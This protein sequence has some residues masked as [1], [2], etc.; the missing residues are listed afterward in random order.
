MIL[1]MSSP[2]PTVEERDQ[3][4]T[5][6][7]P[8]A[9][10][11]SENLLRRSV[12]AVPGVLRHYWAT[13]LIVAI[14][15]VVG[16][17]TGA[18]FHNVS[19]SSD[20]YQSVAY[21]LPPLQ[22]GRW[23]TF[24]SGAFFS[25]ELILYVPILGLLVLAASTFERRV[26]HWQTLVA[27]IGGQVAGAMLT[28]LFLWPFADS[29]W[30]WAAT[31]ARQVDVGIS[32]GG[33]AVL[34]ALTACM[35]PVWRV[36]VRA[37]ISAYLIAM[38]LNAGLL[39]DVEHLLAWCLGLVLG[40]L[41][42]GRRPRSP[43]IRFG[44]RTQRGVVALVI[45]VT[46]I[47]GLVEAVFPGNGGPFHAGNQPYEATSV[48]LGLVVGAVLLLVMADGL[49]RGRRFAW[50]VVTVLLLLSFV[51]LIAVDPSAERTAAMVLLGAQVVLLLATFRAFSARTRR[52]SFRRAGRRLLVVAA[53]LF[54][55]TGVGFL[56]LR[57][58]FVPEASIADMIGEFFSRL[59]FTS[60][61]NIEPATTAANWFVTS[62]G[63]VWIIAI[64]V[65]LVGL[66][67]SSRRPRPQPEQDDR[68]RQ[69]LRTNPATSIEWML[70]W[71]GNTIWFSADGQT[72]IGFRV[73]GS[74]ALCLSDPVGPVGSRV[75]A[76]KE[77]DAYCFERGWLP[78]LFAASEVTAEMAPE[79]GW[80]AVQIAEDSVLALEHLEFKG[81]AWQDVRTAINKAGKQEIRLVVTHW[82]D[83]KPV[84]S[85]QLR[86]ISSGWV[87][88]KSLP[89]M[90]FT[91]GSLAEAEDPDVR[92]HLAIDADSTIEGFTSW[93]PVGDGGEIVGWT[94][95]LMRRRDEG[96]RPVM[97]FLIGA[98]ALQLKDEGYR[99]ISLSA[100]PLAKAPEHLAVNSDQ[101]VLQKLLDFLGN[102]LE[103]YYG[104]RSLLAFKMKFQPE[105]RPMYLVY[106]DESALLEIGIAIARAYMP[107]AKLKDW[108]KM[109]WEMLIPA[110]HD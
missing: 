7:E 85:D 23:W 12:R 81:K 61:G 33:F 52:K 62:I 13:S 48:T 24:F 15:L 105:M 86:A 87:S 26:G 3:V 78:C 83:T 56:V 20:L 71:K 44:R 91:L 77:F 31:L 88:D 16:L 107:D 97:E 108:A 82:A 63:A 49:R 8:P 92:L 51:S 84:I 35:Q 94:I 25:P 79:V 76:M 59:V 50:A 6:A 10:P 74:V 43:E 69:L 28:A 67:Y 27:V 109:S 89:E 55:Y 68:I 106:P 45:A 101:Q 98:S 5:A 64:I 57:E 14:E 102:S 32:A 103:P 72:A 47:S 4:D 60:S 95:D 1:P 19:K 41:L 99:F 2:T 80:K 39:W 30:T 96:F 22:D 104:F 36:R 54:V 58:D 53:A 65:T 93:M 66:L 75:A 90:G 40:P 34:G 70:T 38:L 37:A 21:G 11:A 9:P 17:A 100:A 42:A 18:L 29:G 73:V 46:A 110:G